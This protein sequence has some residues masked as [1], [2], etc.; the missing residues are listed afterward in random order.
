MITHGLVLRNERMNS[1][2]FNPAQGQHFS[3]GIQFHRTRSQGDH[4]MNQR[5]IFLLQPFDVS[6]HLCFG[7]VLTENML[8]QVRS[9]TEKWA[10]NGIIFRDCSNYRNRFVGGLGKY[11]QNPVNILNVC[12]FVNT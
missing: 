2:E 9:F 7:T 10:I 6:C 8:F 4:R 12:S 5:N 11:L 1:I 3:R